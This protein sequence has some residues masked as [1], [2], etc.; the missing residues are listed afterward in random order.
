MKK[1]IA[2]LKKYVVVPLVS[3]LIGFSVLFTMTVIFK[4]SGSL[5]SGGESFA[6]GTDDALNSLNGFWIS[7]LGGL[8][9][10]IFGDLKE[11]SGDQL[12]IGESQF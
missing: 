9:Y 10:S 6:I 5:L 11:N 1:E 12:H 3:G 8:I 7:A 2:I 4:L